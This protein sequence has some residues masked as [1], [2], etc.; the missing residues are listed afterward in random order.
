MKLKENTISNQVKAVEIITDFF[1]KYH[2][3]SPEDLWQRDSVN[4]ALP[5]VFAKVCEALFG[6]EF[7]NIVEE[8]NN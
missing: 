6:K 1:D 3:T 7:E 5:T 8:E 2:I 4:E